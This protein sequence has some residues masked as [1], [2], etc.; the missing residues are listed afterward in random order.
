MDQYATYEKTPLTEKLVQ[1]LNLEYPE[2]KG[3]CFVVRAPGRVN[4]IGEHLDYNGYG[5]LPMALNQSV[6]LAAGNLPSYLHDGHLK[7]CS[8]DSRLENFDGSISECLEFAT[9]GPPKPLKWYHY[10]L[11]GFRGIHDY[12]VE[13]CLPWKPPSMCMMVGR[14][15]G[16]ECLPMCAGL[17]SSSALV[18]AAA[19]ATARCAQLQIDPFT[20]AELC[21]R[22][23]RL[24]G[25]QGGGMDQA[26]CLLANQSPVFIEFTKPKLTVVPV[27]IPPG[28][29][30]VIVDSGVRLHKAASPLFNQR[31]SECRSAVQ[32]LSEA[33]ENEQAKPIQTL[34]DVQRLWGKTEPGQMLSDESPFQTAFG[35][36]ANSL[37]ALRAKHVYSE[38]Q[39]VLD[40]RRLCERFDFSSGD[41]ADAFLQSLGMLMNESQNSCR[42]LYECSCP[43]L[44]R[45]VDVCRSAG[46]YGSR[47]TGAGWGGC[48]VSLVAEATVEH[49]VK[50]VASQ[51]FGES[52]E[53]LKSKIFYSVPGRA[54]GFVLVD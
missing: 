6:F 39:R 35:K 2:T 26:A 16:D 11:C 34:Y 36:A 24:I 7:I 46:A 22:C 33:C 1:L 28:G 47:L 4:I 54:A 9:N 43:E 20:L 44:D 53:A 3:S 48:V 29:C 25:T 41:G 30:F 52:V 23:E 45:L 17:S 50:R 18:V 37:P 19:L 31:V 8:E 14:G 13:H 40:F 38:A 51:Y 49:F 42:D 32:I 21:A 10:V 27:A 12:A 15:S 5:V